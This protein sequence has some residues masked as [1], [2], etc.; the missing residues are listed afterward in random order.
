MKPGNI[1]LLPVQDFGGGA[2]ALRPVVIVAVLPG[3]YQN[4]LVCGISTRLE[5]L[6]PDWDERIESTDPLF[7]ATG[8]HKTSSIRLSFLSAASTRSIRGVI[9]HIDTALLERLRQRLAQRL[10]A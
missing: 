5:Q 6:Q 7:A 4:I 2:S 3:V 9:G 10:G 1:V 8:L